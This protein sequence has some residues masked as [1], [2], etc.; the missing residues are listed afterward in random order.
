MTSVLLSRQEVAEGTMAFRFER[1]RG[2]VF[3]AGQFID[4]TLV[5]P[6]ET[7]AEGESSLH[8]DSDDDPD[9]GVGP[10]LER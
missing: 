5:N 6:P 7:D 8:A 10:T 4:M 3:K 2:L 1:P 9:G